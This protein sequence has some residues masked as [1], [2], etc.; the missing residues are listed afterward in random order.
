MKV[1]DLKVEAS[2]NK[3][4]IIGEISK[5]LELHEAVRFKDI[6]F[7]Q[8]EVNTETECAKVYAIIGK[9]LF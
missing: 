7:F 9:M 3:M 4:Q 1:H 6:T 2:C 8:K 5:M